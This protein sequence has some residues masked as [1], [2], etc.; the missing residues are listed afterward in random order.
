MF[1][2]IAIFKIIYILTIST[3][4]WDDSYEPARPEPRHSAYNLTYSETEVGSLIAIETEQKREW[5]NW[6]RPGVTIRA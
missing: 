4:S 2:L 5:T 3:A 6:S 1:I